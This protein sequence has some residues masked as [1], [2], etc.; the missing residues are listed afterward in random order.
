VAVSDWST[1]PADNNSAPPNGAPEG[2]APSSVNDIMRKMM[3]DIRTFYD[4]ANTTNDSAANV[5]FKGLPQN[6]QTGNYTLVLADAGKEIYYGS[7]HGSGDTV[8]IPA[9][10][11]VA[12]PVGT[13]I[14]ITNDDGTNTLSIAI[15]SDTLRLTGTSSTGTRTLSTYGSCTIT[16]KTSTTWHISGAGVT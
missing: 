3:A 4:G 14:V 13:A 2:M 10:A 8:T 9:N 5:G 15:T 1:T 12:F 7:G 16:K 6:S 11:S